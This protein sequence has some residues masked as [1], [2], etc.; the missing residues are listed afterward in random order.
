MI[1]KLKI[2]LES[3]VS[4]LLHPLIFSFLA[5]VGLAAV[6]D[7]VA[8][9][10]LAVLIYIASTLTNILVELVEIRNQI[11]INCRNQVKTYQLFSRVV[12]QLTNLIS[13]TNRK[14]KSK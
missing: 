13:A 2:Y 12:S 11:I 7:I 6:F 8:A 1:E 5:G 10:Q 14:T 3:L 4:F 9:A